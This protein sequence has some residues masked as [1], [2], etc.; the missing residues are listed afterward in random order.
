MDVQADDV[1]LRYEDPGEFLLNELQEICRN[2][3]DNSDVELICQDN[4][5]IRT[6]S[7]LLA[8][9]S[10]FFKAVLC[11]VWDP[12]RKATIMLPDFRYNGVTPTLIF[13]HSLKANFYLTI[14][15]S[16]DPAF[17]DVCETPPHKRNLTYPTQTLT[18]P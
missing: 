7:S 12:H 6:H 11:E 16:Q 3:S 8:V 17:K 1:L 2:P 9:I 15:F 18:T 4:Y 13:F 5:K 14:G 10:P